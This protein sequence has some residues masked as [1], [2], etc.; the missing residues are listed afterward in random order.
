MLHTNLICTRTVRDCC[1]ANPNCTRIET[2]ARGSA[3]CIHL[4]YSISFLNMHAGSNSANGHFMRCISR[5]CTMQRPCVALNCK[6]SGTT[7]CWCARPFGSCSSPQGSE[8][9]G[10]G[11]AL[12]AAYQRSRDPLESLLVT[13]NRQSW[14]LG[15]DDG[16]M[17]WEEQKYHVNCIQDPE[18]IQQQG[19]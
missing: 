8:Q 19:T 4:M 13:G 18:D 10:A 11:Q 17:V 1:M 14:C 5:E 9:G 15:G 16:H 12:Q 7:G 6:A 2:A 3:T